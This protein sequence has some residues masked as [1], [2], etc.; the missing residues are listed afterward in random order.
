MIFPSFWDEPPSIIRVVEAA[1]LVRTGQRAIFLAVLKS[2]R[3]F[4]KKEGSIAGTKQVQA[5][6]QELRY[7]Q[8][9]R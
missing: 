6:Y 7:M 1:T 9:N 8:R 4:Q 3:L 2:A 5:C